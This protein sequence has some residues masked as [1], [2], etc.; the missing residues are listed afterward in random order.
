MDGLKVELIARDFNRMIEEL[1]AIDPTVEFSQVVTAVAVRVVQGAMNRTKSAKAASIIRRYDS[2]QY[3]TFNGKKYRLENH[4]P[5][6]LWARIAQHRKDRLAARLASR[7]ISKQSWMHVAA[8]LGSSL[9][10]PGYVTAANYKGKQYREDGD[11]SESGSGTEFALTIINSSPIVQSAG[12]RGALIS[13]MQGE[14]GYFQKN[15]EHRAFATLESR[16]KK[17]P[18]IFT[19]PVPPAG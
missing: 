11:K 6:P 12:G 9:V 19:S 15:M 1:A 14:I 8:S 17:Y 5:D 4:Y 16:V 10:A 13:A 3:T 2:K 18:G 7:G